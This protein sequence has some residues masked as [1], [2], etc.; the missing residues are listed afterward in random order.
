[1][2][3]DKVVIVHWGDAFIDNDDFKIAEAKDT[4]PV[5]RKTVGFFLAKNKYGTTLCTDLYQDTP[6]ASS[7]MFIPKGMITK[8]EV[9]HYGE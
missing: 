9:L 6:E 2:K 1:M 7:K 5:M 4:K 3:Q 8:V